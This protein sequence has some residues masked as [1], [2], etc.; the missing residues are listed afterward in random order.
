M[1]HEH[2]MKYQAPQTGI[3]LFRSEDILTTSGFDGEWEDVTEDNDS[4]PSGAS[5]RMPK[6]NF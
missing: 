3:L 2:K 6:V 1:N 4:E 5:F